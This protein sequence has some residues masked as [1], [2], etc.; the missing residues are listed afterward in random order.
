MGHDLAQV[1]E[2]QHDAEHDQAAIENAGVTSLSIYGACAE[3]Y[4]HNLAWNERV[5]VKGI[6][7]ADPMIAIGN[8]DFAM[9]GIPHQKQWRKLGARLDL[10][11]VFLDV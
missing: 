10:D 3:W 1:K 2:R 7:G 4:S 11:V 6:D 8:D 9:R 5:L